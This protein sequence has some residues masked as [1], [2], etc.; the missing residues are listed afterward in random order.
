MY[1]DIEESICMKIHPLKLKLGIYRES[2][3]NIS[4]TTGTN[5][6]NNILHLKHSSVAFAQKEAD[7]HQ[8][9]ILDKCKCW[10]HEIGKIQTKLLI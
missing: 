2:Y 1:D 6:S 9:N 10:G 5:K 7:K 3:Q 4:C 8:K